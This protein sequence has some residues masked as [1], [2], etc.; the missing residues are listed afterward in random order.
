MAFYLISLPINFLIDFPIDF[1]SAY[2]KLC[3]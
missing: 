1:P 2:I 3:K